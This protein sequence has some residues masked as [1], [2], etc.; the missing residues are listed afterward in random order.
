MYKRQVD[1]GPEGGKNGGMIIAEGPPEKIMKEK[2]SFTGTFLKD[3]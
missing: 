1:I 2:K 3:Y